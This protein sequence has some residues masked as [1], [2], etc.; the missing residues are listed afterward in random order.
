MNL[1]VIGGSYFYGRVFVMEATKEHTVTVLN[2]GTYSMKEFGA[3][4]IKGDRHSAEVM[5]PVYRGLR[6]GYRLLCL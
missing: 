3:K 6:C 1:L 5:E 4:E 2:R